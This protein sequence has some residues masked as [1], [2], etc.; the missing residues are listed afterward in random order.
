M[1]LTAAPRGRPQVHFSVKN[2]NLTFS[3]DGAVSIS[4]ELL[5]NIYVISNVQNEQF[6]NR[7]I[8]NY[9]L[10]ITP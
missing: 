8:D 4:E 6:K 9:F 1:H 7:V 2:G 3:L 5:I 10:S